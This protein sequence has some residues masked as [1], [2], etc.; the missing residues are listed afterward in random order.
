MTYLHDVAPTHES[1]GRIVWLSISN[2]CHFDMDILPYN[3]FRNFSSFLRK[4]KYV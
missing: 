3:Y 1:S 2:S 4:I